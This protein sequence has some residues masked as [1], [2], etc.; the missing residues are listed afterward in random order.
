MPWDKIDA[1][2]YEPWKIENYDA[3][4]ANSKKRLEQNPQFQLI[5]ENAK[6]ISKRRDENVYS[7]QLDKFKKEQENLDAEA[8]KYKPISEY[9]NKLQFK[10]LPNEMALMEKD[11]LFKEKRV[12]WHE[13]LAKDVYVE[14]ALN[15]LSDMQSK[16]MVKAKLP[17]KGKKGK[18]VGA[19]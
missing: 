1:A 13:S 14:E 7:L 4:I 16:N 19:L 8:K 5:D 9:K 17:A 10:S 2:K 15:V 6:W 18:L 11:S 12:R 3:V